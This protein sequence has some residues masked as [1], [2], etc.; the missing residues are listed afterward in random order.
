MTEFICVIPA[1]YGSQRLPGK[2]LL[3]LA[4]KPLVQW[5]WESAIA[6]DA[7]SVVIA[8]DD[9]RIAAAAKGFGA[10]V[11]MTRD[12]HPSGTDR[13]AE[14]ADRLALS[15]DQIVVNLQGDEPSVSPRL[16]NQVARLLIDNPDASMSTLSEAIGDPADYRNPNVVKVVRADTGRALYFSR[17]SIPF[18]RDD[19]QPLFGG[20]VQRHLGLYGYRAGLLR[21]FVQWPESTLEQT[22]KLEQLRVLQ[23]GEGIWIDE[24]C[25]PSSPGID[26][27]AQLDA[28][29]RQWAGQS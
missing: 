6:S 25:A 3:M 4:G 7:S 2:P 19:D 29:N 12:D 1:R 21:R 27:Q 28:L 23:A 13:L 26:T 8:T 11:V 16:L 18:C 9:D 22:E 5:A 14:V 15:D 10:E 20:R 24:A 17:A